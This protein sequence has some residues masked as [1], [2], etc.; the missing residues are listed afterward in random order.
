[1]RKIIEA[2]YP[3][4]LPE[5]ELAISTGLRKGSMYGLTW[6]MVDWTGRMLNIPTSKN[7]NGEALHIPLDGAK[8]EDIG[9]LLGHKN[10]TMTKRYVHLGP[11]RLHDVVASLNSHSTPVAP[12]P[13]PET[14]ISA[15]FLI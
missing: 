4:H 12:E 14:E 1:M 6:E 9:E 15:S 3:E 13:E 5:F 8:P 10:L 7:K 11:N 2:D